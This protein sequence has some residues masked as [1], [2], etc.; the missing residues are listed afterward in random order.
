MMAATPALLESLATTYGSLAK[1]ASVHTADPGT[2][3]ANEAAV[4]RQPITWNS[5]DVD[6]TIT[7]N[8]MTFTGITPPL[9]L[10]HIGIWSAITGGTFLDSVENGV[11]ITQG[12]YL[13]TLA[14]EQAP[15][16]EDDDDE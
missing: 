5:G 14:F 1:F 6:G 2:T 7:S 3:G 11:T 13:V 4:A 16:A 10:T 9:S 12:D 15:I 8:T